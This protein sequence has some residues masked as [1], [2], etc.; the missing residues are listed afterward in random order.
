MN[1][2]FRSVVRKFLPPWLVDR[3][4]DGLVNGYKFVYANVLP[5]DLGMQ[6]IREGVTAA[7]PGVGTPTALALTGQARGIIRGF[8]EPDAS[9]AARQLNWRYD[10]QRTGNPYTIMRQ[11]QGYL[12][13]FDVDMFVVNAQSTWYGL[14][15]DGT[16]T[17]TATSA[18]LWDD[19]GIVYRFWVILFPP[20]ELWDRDGTWGDGEV[21]GA[22]DTTWG[23]T[24]TREQVDT[25]RAIIR[26]RKSAE[27][28]CQG[29]IV[30]F[31][32]TAPFDP[33]NGAP[34][35]P[36]GTW[37]YYSKND[38]GTQV[39]ARDSRAIYLYSTEGFG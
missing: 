3:V 19:L 9:Y 15:A 21:W 16:V 38:G 33:A 12:T 37:H 2:Q 31:D 26:Q 27:G 10:W 1:L 8:A 4:Q 6:F 32:E 24:A 25:V 28:L 11:L 14:A 20:A 7:W 39:P 17:K 23:S 30:S 36:D 22:N 35:L 5:L 34:P 18:W 13:G 29:V